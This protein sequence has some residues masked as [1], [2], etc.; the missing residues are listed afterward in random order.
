MDADE[1]RPPD[2]VEEAVGRLCE[3]IAIRP[4]TINSPT[5]KIIGSARMASATGSAAPR[6]GSAIIWRTATARRVQALWVLALT[7]L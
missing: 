5:R 7:G 2:I 6:S 4:P 1:P 3:A